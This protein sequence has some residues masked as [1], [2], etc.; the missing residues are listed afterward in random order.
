MDTGV[1][2]DGIMVGINGH[3]PMHE[4]AGTDITEEEAVT[5]LPASALASIL[6]W[7]NDIATDIHLYSGAST[8]C[9]LPPFV[10]DFADK[11]KPSNA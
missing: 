5:S 8:H 9:N 10:T 11:Y 7:S 4:D 6:K 2:T 1:Q 3:K